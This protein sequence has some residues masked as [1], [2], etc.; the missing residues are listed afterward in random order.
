MKSKTKILC[1]ITVCV[2]IIFTGCQ[3][4]YA[5]N[6]DNNSTTCE[7]IVMGNGKFT[8]HNDFIYFTNR[9]NIYEYDMETKST[10]I[11]NSESADVRSL[12]IQDNYIY[13]ACAGL[14]RITKDGKKVQQIFESKKGC[15]QL[16]VEDAYAYFLD[17]VEGCL[18]RRNL[19]EDKE[20]KLLENVLAYYI[21][22]NNIYAVAKD[23]DIP[24]LFVS[25]KEEIDFRIQEL[26]FIPISVLTKD[27]TIYASERQS[28]QIVKISSKGEE[29]LPIYGTYYQVIDDKIIY[30]DSKT[31]ENSCFTLVE[32]NVNTGES[33]NIYENVFDFNI[34]ENKYVC[35]QHMPVQTAEYYIYNLETGENLLM[36]KEGDSAWKN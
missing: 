16:Y 14:K 20:K 26:S 3:E 13:F 23:K 1:I 19:K 28:H 7:N 10:I 33:K 2:S 17:S 32:Y 6:F 30:L 27:S 9:E 8:L 11:L 5:G 34:L 25:K 35:I 21:D 15:I 31:Y 4:K 12:Y 18:Y 24:Y 22:E 36:Y 29:R